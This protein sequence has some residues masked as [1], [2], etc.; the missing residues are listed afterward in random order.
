M[1][2]GKLGVYSSSHR[3]NPTV[4]SWSGFKALSMSWHKAK[5]KSYDMRTQIKNNNYDGYNKNDDYNKNERH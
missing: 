5:T 2:S 3:A 1:D 4:V